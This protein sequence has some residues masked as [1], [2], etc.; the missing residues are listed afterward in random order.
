MRFHI[1]CTNIKL[2][3][4]QTLFMMVGGMIALIYTSCYKKFTRS[5]RMVINHNLS[6][7]IYIKKSEG[8]IA[9]L[10]DLPH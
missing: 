8:I 4:R 6:T 2:A 3:E 9:I 1:D 5:G 10:R 7:E